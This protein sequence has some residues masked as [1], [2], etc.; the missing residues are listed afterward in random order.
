MSGGNYSMDKKEF[1]KI[2][3]ENYLIM[4]DMFNFH[5]EHGSNKNINTV[6]ADFQLYNLNLILNIK[7]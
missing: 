6:I 5:L 1:D 4:K 7:Y 3:F 2:N